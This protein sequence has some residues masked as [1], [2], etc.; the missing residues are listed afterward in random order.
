[1]V[2]CYLL[3]HSILVYYRFFRGHFSITSLYGRSFGFN[4]RWFFGILIIGVYFWHFNPLFQ[5]LNLNNLY[6][7]PFWGLSSQFVPILV[8]FLSS[9]NQGSFLTIIALTTMWHFFRLLEY[10]DLSRCWLLGLVYKGVWLHPN[11]KPW[12][13]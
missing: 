13:C 8:E 9:W 11:N 12:F 4:L 5:G 3:D 10:E 1:M 7:E 6:Q 2:C